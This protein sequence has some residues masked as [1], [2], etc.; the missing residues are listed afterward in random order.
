MAASLGHADVRSEFGARFSLPFAVA[1]LICHGRSGLDN[2]DA[3]SVADPRIQA[4]ARRV[5]V[6]ED[7]EFTRVF[8][9]QQPTEVTLVLADGSEMVERAEFHR[10]EAEHPHP[11]DAVRRKFMDLVAPVWDRGRGEALYDRVLNLERVPDVAAL[12]GD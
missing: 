10:G 1:S 3:A 12:I 6:T 5:T 11:P 2:Y 9:Q 8:P 7:P 4:L